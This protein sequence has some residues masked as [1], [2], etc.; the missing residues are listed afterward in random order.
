M[1]TPE[2][3]FT[4]ADQLDPAVAY[5]P[6]ERDPEA[7]I[8]DAVEQ[9]TPADPDE[10]PTEIHRGLEVDEFDAIEQGQPITPDPDEY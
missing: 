3:E 8:G 9:A 6:D 5:D 1:T 4:P 2:A 7:P 10:A